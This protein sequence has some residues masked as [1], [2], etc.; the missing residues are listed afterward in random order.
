[1]HGQSHTRDEWLDSHTEQVLQGDTV[2]A[3][4]YV[5]SL[6]PPLGV[7]QR[8]ED[9]LAQLTDLRDS[10][11]LDDFGV[12]LWGGGICLCD[13]CRDGT[14]AESMLRNVREFEAWADER[15]GVSLPFERRTVESK[16]TET[17]VRD[18]DVP[19]ICLAVRS[20]EEL[21]GVTE[22]ADRG[23]AEPDSETRNSVAQI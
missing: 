1:M 4:M 7:R 21:A 20:D 6:S 9:L 19:A 18:L 16:I 17:T 23:A 3:A 13:V 11:I 2:E 5:R 22:L 15:E 14:V 8:Q 12:N 10:G